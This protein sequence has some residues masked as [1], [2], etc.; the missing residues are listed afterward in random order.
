MK[1]SFDPLRHRFWESEVPSGR[2]LATVKFSQIDRY[3]SRVGTVSLN[4]LRR[5]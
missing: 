1:R 4:D 2:V 5:F 3:K